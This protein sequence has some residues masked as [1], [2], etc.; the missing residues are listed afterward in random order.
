LKK[1]KV[2]AIQI[3]QFGFPLL[4]SL[5]EG[6][7]AFRR[8]EIYA[9]DDDITTVEIDV[10]GA[11]DVD[12]SRLEKPDWGQWFGD[13]LTVFKNLFSFASNLDQ[14]VIIFGNSKAIVEINNLMDGCIE[15]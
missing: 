7:Q 3:V 8:L 15:F 1:I 2:S 13:G 9:Y 6:G 4:S 14:D 12:V 10:S 11:P 5:N